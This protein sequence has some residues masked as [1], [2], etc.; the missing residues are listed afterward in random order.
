M[1]AMA[2]GSSNLRSQHH[3][4]EKVFVS[5]LVHG[6]CHQLLP[7]DLKHFEWAYFAF[8][9]T[10]RGNMCYV[11]LLCMS[12]T[13]MLQTPKEFSYMKQKTKREE[14]QGVTAEA[15]QGVITVSAEPKEQTIPS[16][17]D[18]LAETFV[19]QSLDLPP[20]AA[21]VCSKQP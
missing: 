2:G 5:W 8:V 13:T 11:K 1:S 14:S 3:S 17:G 7:A 20:K 15:S 19:A 18:Q 16:I 10:V 21:Q 12:I 9:K 4:G 6:Y